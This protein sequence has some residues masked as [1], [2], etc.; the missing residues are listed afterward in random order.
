MLATGQKVPA[1]TCPIS[2][3]HSNSVLKNPEICHPEEPKA[4]KD[5]GI[6]LILQ[7]Q[8]FFASLRMR[9]E[10][11]TIDMPEAVFNNL[12]RGVS[13][14]LLAFVVASCAARSG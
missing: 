5:L 12:L 13:G 2:W 9:G 3:S 7:M 1:L 8:R 6:C 4:T 11:L 10:G 14:C